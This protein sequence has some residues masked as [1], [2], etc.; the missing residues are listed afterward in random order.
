MFK[1]VLNNPRLY[2]FGNMASKEQ[3]DELNQVCLSSLANKLAIEGLA[4]RKLDEDIILTEDMALFYLRV[5]NR[6]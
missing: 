5:V 4:E 6:L 2:N 1:H 3:V